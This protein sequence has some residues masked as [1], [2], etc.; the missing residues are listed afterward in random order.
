[1][2]KEYKKEDILNYVGN[3][4]QLF[5]VRS[6]TYND[7]KA[8]GSRAVMVNNGSGLQFTV[9]PDRALDIA[10]LTLN[11]INLVFINNA[12][13]VD[14]RFFEYKALEFCRTWSAG[15]LS[16]CGLTQVGGNFIDENGEEH[17]LHGRHTATPSD[18][19][20]GHVDWIDDKPVIKIRG[21]M[22]ECRLFGENIELTREITC[23]V[24]KNRIVVHDVVENLDYEKQPFM[25]LYHSN[26]GYPLVC[27]D[28]YVM[29]PSEGPVP[30]DSGKGVEH[31]TVERYNLFEK[32]S[33]GFQ[34]EVYYHKMKS[35]KDGR[36]SVACINEKLGIGVVMYYNVNEL[37]CFNQW[38]MMG[39]GTYVLGMEPAN[40]HPIG[41]NNEAKNG[42]LKYIE[43]REK[44]EITVVYEF[45]SCAEQISEYKKS[46][47][48]LM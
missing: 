26:F 40:C 34:E 44:K 18:H 32:P 16:T 12:G 41:R 45:L 19:V 25:I 1:M 37:D 11:G 27:E 9:T 33:Q 30:R 43:A 42:N 22:K 31:Y 6:L 36:T 23:E 28:S 38:K 39:K 4:E 14:P 13:V 15:L 24:G 2:I 17:G 47:S 46:V 35:D 48:D 21:E 8:R 10:D 7:G 29:I 20:C 5:S 3:Y